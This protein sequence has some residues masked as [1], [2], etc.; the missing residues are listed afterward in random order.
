MGSG[1]QEVLTTPWE[2]YLTDPSSSP[3][4]ATWR[5]ELNQSLAG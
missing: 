1:S 5:A 3:D 4:L 2:V